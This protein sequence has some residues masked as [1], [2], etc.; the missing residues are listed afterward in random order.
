MGEVRL[1]FNEVCSEISSFQKLSRKQSLTQDRCTGVRIDRIPRTPFSDS[2]SE[3]ILSKLFGYRDSPPPIGPPLFEDPRPLSLVSVSEQGSKSSQRQK[4]KTGFRRLV[5]G[6]LNNLCRTSLA[7]LEAEKKPYNYI[8]QLFNH[9]GLGIQ[10]FTLF[11]RIPR[12]QCT[13]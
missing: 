8:W 12:P 7:G 10:T 4:V 11:V 5:Y 9:R 3:Q 1:E 6:E 2:L 13:C